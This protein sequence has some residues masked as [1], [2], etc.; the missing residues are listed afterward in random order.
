MT[1]DAQRTTIPR[2]ILIARLD[3]LGDVVLSTPVIRHMRK[4]FPDAYI[5]FMVRSPNRDVVEN[6][7]DLNEVILYDKAGSEKSFF[8]AARFALGALRKKK[9]DTAIA[10]HPTTRTHIAFFL[11]GIPVRI[12]YARKMD[13]LLTERIPHSK[14]EGEMHEALYN[15][16]LLKKAGFDVSGAD[17][18]PYIVTGGRD[19]AFV[20]E[21]QGRMKIG[22]N[23]I[24]VHA[25]ASCSSKRW[26]AE[27]FAEAADV[28]GAKYGAEI[29]IV[30]GKDTEEFSRKVVS[31]MKRKTCDLTGKLGIGALA[32]VLSRSRLFI[33]NDSGPVHVAVA[34][35]T[36][37]VVIFGRKNPGLSP[38][39]WGPLGK[40]DIVLHKD[41]GCVKCLAHECQIGFKCLDAVTVDDVVRAAEKI[42]G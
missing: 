27:R 25:G 22:P 30:G 19:K 20:D 28:L 4:I 24:A 39:R 16:Q 40:R 41:V 36:P 13:R 38:K 37:V 29:V 21:L 3:R 6:N 12:G 23:I 26:P 35:G 5:A 31:A 15:F 33:S 7:P 17:P 1:D 10:L 9:F 14:H 8:G 18:R 42:L 32:E 11:A 2:R 34:V